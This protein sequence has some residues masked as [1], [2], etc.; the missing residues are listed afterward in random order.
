MCVEFEV[1]VNLNSE[2]VFHNVVWDIYILFHWA[3]QSF[4][5]QRTMMMW[6]DSVAAILNFCR[7]QSLCVYV[8][9]MLKY[10]I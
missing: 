8:M 5:L 6:E 1:N 7:C 2:D 10:N 3:V 9:S 4:I